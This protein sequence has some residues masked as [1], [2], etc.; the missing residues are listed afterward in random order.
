MFKFKKIERNVQKSNVKCNHVNRNICFY[1][2]TCKLNALLL[3]LVYK[4]LFIVNF[5]LYVR[6]LHVPN[7]YIQLHVLKELMKMNKLLTNYLKE[8][9]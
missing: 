8:V 6:L 7:Y 1:L 4:I 3:E 9:V 2:R 5:F